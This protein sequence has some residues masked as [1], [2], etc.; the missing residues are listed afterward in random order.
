M[1]NNDGGKAFPVPNDCE[2]HFNGGMSL[3]DY[4]AAAA[5]TGYMATGGPQ[6]GLKLVSMEENDR[7]IAQH[8]YAIA[9]AMIIERGL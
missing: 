9:D 8:A 3:R 6:D 1:T 7:A 4:F 2:K 5:L